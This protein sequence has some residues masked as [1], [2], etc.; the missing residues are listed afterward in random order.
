VLTQNKERFP[1]GDWKLYRFY[2]GLAKP[3]GGNDDSDAT[4]QHHVKALANW[5]KAS[6]HSTAAHIAL[7]EGYS[8]YAW[9]ARGT[10][11][12]DTVTDRGW[13]EFYERL[14]RAASVD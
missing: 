4:W 8:D 14:A 11:Y 6:P 12:A 9:N 3:E 1:G 2:Q 10:G 7:A 13:K 5:L